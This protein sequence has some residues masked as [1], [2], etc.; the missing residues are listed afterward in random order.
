MSNAAFKRFS[1]EAIQSQNHT[2]QSGQRN[3]RLRLMAQFPSLTEAEWEDILPKKDPLLVVKCQNHLSLV[4]LGRR[5]LFFQERDDP[6]LPTLRL[7]HQYPFMLPKMQMD[8]GGCKFVLGGA[9]IMCPGLTHPTGGYMDEVSAGEVVALFVE[10]KEH[11]VAVG[12]AKMS[13]QAIREVNKGHGVENVHYM[14]DGL[15]HNPDV[16]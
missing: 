14:G 8:I 4:V 16:E 15:W 10:G 1:K 5:I 11:P 6:Y 3:I 2:K 7:L 9:N 13:T 12:V